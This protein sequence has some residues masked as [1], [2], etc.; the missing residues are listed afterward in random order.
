MRNGMSVKEVYERLDQCDRL[1]KAYTNLRFKHDVVLGNFY[2]IADLI[3]RTAAQYQNLISDPM[4][5][6]DDVLEFSGKISGLKEAWRIINNVFPNRIL[7]DCDADE[8]EEGESDG[9]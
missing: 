5:S 3:L 1:E 6:K 2:L 8:V 9:N 7:E 4:A